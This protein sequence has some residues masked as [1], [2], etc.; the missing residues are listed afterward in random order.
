[1][2]LSAADIIG[3]AVFA[4]VAIAVAVA[5]RFMSA[6]RAVPAGIGERIRDVRQS[7]FSAVEEV[8]EGEAAPLFKPLDLMRQKY[9]WIADLRTRFENATYLVGGTAGTKKP[10]MLSCAVGFIL[11]MIAAPSLTDSFILSAL[12]CLCMALVAGAITIRFLMTRARNLFFQQFPD[13]IDLIVRA[14]KAGI[15][16]PQALS[17]VGSE[18]PAPTGIIFSTIA[19]QLSIGRPI[20]ETLTEAVDRVPLA[21]FRFFA[22]TL[23]LQRETGGQLSETLENLSELLRRRKNMGLKLK[24]LTSEIRASSK[25]LSAIP[26]AIGLFFY[27]TN[28]THIE[29][30]LNHPD[31]Q[32]MLQ[33]SAISL[34][35]GL[36]IISKMSKIR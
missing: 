14:S 13:A 12:L 8:E 33:Y 22:V 16:V 25:V 1:M 2:E 3:I 35:L 19:D 4:I 21:E 20:E 6:A 34:V 10:F 5:A 11:G 36:F 31:G 17:A 18:I 26:F 27:F 15:S 24:A 9:R 28:P 23:I 32:G 29:L 30:L 7:A